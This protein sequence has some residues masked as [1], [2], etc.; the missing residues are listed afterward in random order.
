M[1][2]KD[3]KS[4]F[5]NIGLLVSLIILGLLLVFSYNKCMATS[6]SFFELSTVD[7]T[8]I[9]ETSSPISTIQ[10]DFQSPQNVRINIE[11]S[12]LIVNFNIDITAGKK[13]PNKFMVVLAQYDDKLQPTGN[14]RFFISNEYNVNP[15][16]VFNENINNTSLCEIVNGSP[17]CSYVFNNLDIVDTV[18]NPYYYK[19][20]IS[21]VYNDGNSEFTTPYNV[22][23]SNKLFT[24]SSN[25]QN[26]N[27]QFEDFIKYKQMQ[28]Q[29]Q[30][31]DSKYLNATSTVDGQYEF[32]K[33]QLGG[34]PSNLIMD[35]TS[36]KQNLL[37]DLVNKSMSQAILN[38][39]VD[40][41]TN[42]NNV[43]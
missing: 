15:S 27:S 21:A 25:I 29:A 36:A 3:G 13:I 2:L 26:Q 19:L 28:A 4:L 6:E 11:G 18:G 22:I 5:G 12:T 8:I 38:I 17:S 39:N 7:N 24:L 30:Q 16:V 31:A 20:G 34:Y 32:I 9:P 33:S 23:N 35:P 41:P 1:F 37:T 42:T 40:T 43:L 10:T 14:N